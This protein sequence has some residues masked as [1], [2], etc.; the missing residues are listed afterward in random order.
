[1]ETLAKELLE[2]SIKFNDIKSKIDSWS[3][4]VKRNDSNRLSSVTPI[5]YLAGV[6]SK[7]LDSFSRS[8]HKC[9]FEAAKRECLHT[10]IEIRAKHQYTVIPQRVDDMFVTTEA[11]GPSKFEFSRFLLELSGEPCSTAP[12]I[13][14]IIDA[15]SHQSL[16]PARSLHDSLEAVRNVRI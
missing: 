5:S 4:C 13:A 9:H 12:D 3:Q 14:R 6:N 10:G 16:V 1:M 7:D 11:L 8:S 15:G 2:H